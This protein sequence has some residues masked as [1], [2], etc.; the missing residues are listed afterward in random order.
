[1]IVGGLAGLLTVAAVGFV[2]QIETANLGATGQG[3]ADV[4]HCDVSD[5]RF[6]RSTTCYGEWA[7]AG[8]VYFGELPGTTDDLSPVTIHYDPDDPGT[9]TAAKGRKTG[10][11]RAGR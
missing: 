5:G 6:G 11:R 10:L 3:A 8:R 4:L 1:M 7:V 2:V 9:L